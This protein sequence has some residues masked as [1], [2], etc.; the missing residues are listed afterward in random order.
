MA[1]YVKLG[2]Y[3]IMFVGALAQALGYQ[4]VGSALIG[5]AGATGFTTVNKD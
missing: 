3:G 2:M 5:L 1:K 4:E